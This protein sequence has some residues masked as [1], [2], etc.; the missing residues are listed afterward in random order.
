ME[1]QRARLAGLLIVIGI[2][3]IV[4]MERLAEWSSVGYQASSTAISGLGSSFFGSYACFLE[5]CNAIQQPASI[6]FL[7]GLLGLGVLLFAVVRLESSGITRSTMRLLYVCAF[8]MLLLCV[9]YMPVYLGSADTNFYLGVAMH[10]IGAVL[11]V[12]AGAVLA[13]RADVFVEPALRY[14]SRVVGLLIVAAVPFYAYVF[15][16]TPAWTLGAGTIERI[17]FGLLIGWFLGY[18]LYLMWTSVRS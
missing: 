8:A 1:Q 14:I 7:A 5:K 13:L 4:L 18:G 16:N 9:S 11:L 10:L 17:G 3:W 12:G 2:L 6:I 15:V